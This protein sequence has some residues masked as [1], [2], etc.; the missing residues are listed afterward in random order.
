VV[1]IAGAAPPRTTAPIVASDGDRLAG[2]ISHHRC[3]RFR[4]QR[5]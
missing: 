4:T 3:A 1:V 2:S 5:L